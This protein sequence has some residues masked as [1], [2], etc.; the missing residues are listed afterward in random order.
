MKKVVAI[1]LPCFFVLALCA[2]FLPREV[3]VTDFAMN[4]AVSVTV[5]SRNCQKIADKALDEIKRVEKLMSAT[6]KDSDVARINSA[7]SGEYTKVSDEVYNLIELCLEVSKIS[8]GAFDITVNPISELWNFTSENP[9]V[10]KKEDIKNLLNSVGYE[11]IAL[12]PTDKSV[13][14]KKEGMSISLGAVA[15]GYAADCVAEILTSNGVSDAIVDI[16]GNIYALGEKKIGIQTPFK[17]RGEYSTVCTVKDKSVVTSG[18]YERYFKEDGKIY[19]HI[20]DTKTGY[21]CESGLISAT[22]ISESSA[23]CDALSTA[24][25]ALGEDG[26]RDILSQFD[27]VSAILLTEDGR[28]VEI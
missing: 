28:Q 25:F 18:P 10:P 1:I 22:I 14:L 11:N 15:K 2:V 23:L 16:G 7:P 6:I 27:A 19:H 12:N 9:S 20:I 21:P 3:T 24:A 4:T 5:R 26:A 13:C 8:G 17:A